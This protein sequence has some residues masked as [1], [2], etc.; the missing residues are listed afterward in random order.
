MLQ[1]MHYH[2][3]HKPHNIDKMKFDYVMRHAKSTPVSSRS[4]ISTV[5]FRGKIRRR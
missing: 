1:S 2:C 4:L 3:D 5:A